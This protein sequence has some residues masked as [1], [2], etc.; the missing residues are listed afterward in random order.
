MVHMAFSTF[1]FVFQKENFNEKWALI[2]WIFMFSLLIQILQ[3]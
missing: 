1:L 2:C 3:M